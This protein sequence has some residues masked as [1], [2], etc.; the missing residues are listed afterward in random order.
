LT[1][2]PDYLSAVGNGVTIAGPLVNTNLPQAMEFD[3]AVASGTPS[4]CSAI[5]TLIY[6]RTD[7]TGNT[8]SVNE[9]VDLLV[10]QPPAETGKTTPTLG[11]YLGPEDK[12][13]NASFTPTRFIPCSSSLT[14]GSTTPV[15]GGWDVSA[16]KPS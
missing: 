4:I 1:I 2:T 3:I 11:E 12:W 5:G 15:S 14:G 9:V 13:Q 7:G 8:T 6:T 10:N 16:G